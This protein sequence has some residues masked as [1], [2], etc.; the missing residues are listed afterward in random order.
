M[1]WSL[2]I[3]GVPNNHFGRIFL[4]GSN[5]VGPVFHVR[6]YNFTIDTIEFA[7]CH[8]GPQLFV[9]DASTRVEVGTFKL[10]NGTYGAGFSGKALVELKGNAYM[11]MGN[12]H[13]GGNNMVMNMTS[14]KCYMF[15]VNS[16]AGGGGYLRVEFI[17]ALWTT[18][19]GNSYVANPGTLSRGLD[20]GGVLLTLWD[21]NDSSASTTQNRTRLFSAANGRMSL[22]RGNTD[23]TLAIGNENVQMFNTAFTAPR[24]VTLPSAGGAFNGLE[25]TIVSAGAVNGAN[26]LAVKSGATTIATLTADNTSVRVGFRRTS[27]ADWVVIPQ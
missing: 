27:S 18:R 3:N 11:N 8:Q 23:I 12:F 20:I 7:A 6:G 9:C 17:D 5:M 22:D 10:E 15:T 1:D 24:A 26:T 4:D 13:M 19:S 14:L 16:G 21:I 2:C 25:Y